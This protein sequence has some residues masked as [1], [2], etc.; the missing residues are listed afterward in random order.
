M[1]L[2]DLLNVMQPNVKICIYRMNGE[3]MNV[4]YYVDELSEIKHIEWDVDCLFT[5]K[6]MVHINITNK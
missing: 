2:K 4:K 3:Y 1:K 6:E 5:D